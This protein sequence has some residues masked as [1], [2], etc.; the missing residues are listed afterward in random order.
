M[1]QYYF[2]STP[3]N[4]YKF[5]LLT[6]QRPVSILQLFWKNW[7]C[8]IER[9]LVLLYTTEVFWYTLLPSKD[10]FVPF[11]PFHPYPLAFF[12]FFF[13]SPKILYEI[14]LVPFHS[15]SL[16]ILSLGT[17]SPDMPDRRGAGCCSRLATGVMD[18]EQG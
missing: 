15:S 8:D 7:F 4:L 10:L 14:P 6:I 11:I 3:F 5:Y 17:L 12:T 13:F 2:L 18:G 9:S 16:P 1:F